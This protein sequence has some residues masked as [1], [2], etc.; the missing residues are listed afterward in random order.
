MS[1]GVLAHITLDILCMN[2][3]QNKFARFHPRRP[4]YIGDSCYPNRIMRILN[5]IS[6]EGILSHLP[7]PPPPPN[8]IF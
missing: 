8:V 1:G 5:A 4:D 3:L 6:I 7:L 2:K